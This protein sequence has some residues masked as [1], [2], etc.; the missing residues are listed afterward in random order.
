VRIPNHVHAAHPWVIS[1]IAPD[2]TLLDAWALPVRGRRADFA[3]FLDVVT[4]LDPARSD[5]APTR[6]LFALRYRLGDWFGWDDEKVVHAIPGCTETSLRQRL[7]AELRGS[8]R[9]P[10]RA[11]E[12]GFVALYETADEWAAEISNATVHGVLQLAW[13]PEGRGRYRAE[14]AVYVKSRGLFTTAYLA[15]ITP[16]RILIVYPA[17]VRQIARAWERATTR[18]ASPPRRSAA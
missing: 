5:S 17:L 9:H 6:A 15:A 12:R 2:F 18:P 10:V 14:L 7:P 11:M 1:R 8:V 13:V 16:F 3:R 4:A